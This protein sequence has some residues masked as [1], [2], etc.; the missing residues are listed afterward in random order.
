MNGDKLIKKYLPLT[1][2]TYYILLSLVE[3][4]H[5]YAIMQYVDSLSKGKI[6]LG[7]GT[8]YGALSKLQK[9]ELIEMTLADDRKKCYVLTDV[10]KK[11]LFMEIRRL[12]ELVE[13]G[14]DVL[15]RLGDGENE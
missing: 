11:L 14:M 7:P 6:T 10:G 8:L 2:S 3:P 5:G 4:R 12:A 15:D 13:H 9:E 1:E